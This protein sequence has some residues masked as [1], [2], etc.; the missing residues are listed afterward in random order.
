MAAALAQCL[1][2]L[3]LMLALYGLARRLIIWVYAR[4]M[5]ALLGYRGDRAR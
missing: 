1:I 5:D 2:A 4:Y 3:L